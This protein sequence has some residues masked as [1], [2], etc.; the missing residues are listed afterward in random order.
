MD[1]VD[2]IVGIDLDLTADE[3]DVMNWYYINIQNQ[4]LA[5]R[6][7]RISFRR[8]MYERFM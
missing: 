3:I 7:T 8:I 5:S 4:I 6:M 1:L 2:V